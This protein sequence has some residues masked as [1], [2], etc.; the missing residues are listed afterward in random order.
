M[1]FIWSALFNGFNVRDDGF[2]IF[3]GLKEN[4]GFLKVF[5]IIILVQ[6]F[7]VNAALIPV[8]VFEWIS[9]MFSCVPFGIEGWLV[10]I[11]LAFL[12]IPVDMLR[13]LVVKGLRHRRG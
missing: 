11:A 12:V 3:S 6:A 2:K 8:P 5:F 4:P 7:I 10:V 13:K 9:S 1:L